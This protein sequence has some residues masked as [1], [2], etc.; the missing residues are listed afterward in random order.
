MAITTRAQLLSALKAK[1]TLLWDSGHYGSGGNRWHWGMSAWQNSGTGSPA[2]GG[3]L[4][5]TNTA[6]GIVPTAGSGGFPALANFPPAGQTGYLGA[7]DYTSTEGGRF[8]IAHLLFRAGA[9]SFN[10]NT[11]L[12]SQPSYADQVPGGDYKGTELYF[13]AASAFT[14]NPTV[15]V[16][17]TNQD[18]VAGRTTGA[19]AFGYAPAVRA[20]QQLPL[21]AG[22]SGIQKIESVVCTVATIGTF[23]ILVVRP[24]WQSRVVR[25][26][27][28]DYPHNFHGPDLTDLAVIP[29][30]A[31][32]F[33]MHAADPNTMPDG[34]AAHLISG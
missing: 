28:H 20:M 7:V 21:Q 24:L 11:T 6:N 14:G 19:F 10:A 32:L 31:A 4:G 12:A 8:K 30:N 15:T 17:Y 18:G 29:A 9:Y 25:G 33:A 22:D 26:N 34:V 1:R 23:D 5:G 27:Q 16:T 2:G 3:S 13:V